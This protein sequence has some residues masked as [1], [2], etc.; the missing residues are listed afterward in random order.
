MILDGIQA[1]KY[2]FLMVPCSGYYVEGPIL[3]NRKNGLQ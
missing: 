3:V 2:Y 1:N